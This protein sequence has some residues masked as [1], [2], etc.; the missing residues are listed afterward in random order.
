MKERNIKERLDRAITNCAWC[1]L[2]PQASLLHLL[3]ISSNHSLI[4]LN[5]NG[6]QKRKKKV[7]QVEEMW[8]RDLTSFQVIELAWKTCVDGSSSYKGKEKQRVTKKAL[9]HWN[10]HSFGHIKKRLQ[11]L[12]QKL[13]QLQ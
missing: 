9:Q 5:T 12:L 7:F 3:A 13:N 11:Q 8:T 10:K 1:E 2:F 6:G 4:L